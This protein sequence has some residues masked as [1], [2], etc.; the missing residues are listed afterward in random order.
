M[1]TSPSKDHRQELA[2]AD[3]EDL[4]EQQRED[5]GLVL[6]A[7]AQEGGTEGQHHHQGQGGDDV[8]PPPPA[9]RADPEGR[10]Q[11]EHPQARSA[12]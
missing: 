11:R 6:R 7:L 12:G 4:A 2:G 10:H 8:G 9:E 5:L 1:H 3:P